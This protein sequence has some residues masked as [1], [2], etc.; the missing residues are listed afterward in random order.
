MI[1]VHIFFPH[2]N[3]QL[4]D[5]FFQGLSID[6]KNGIQIERD[7]KNRFTGVAYVAFNDPEDL[8]IALKTDFTSVNQ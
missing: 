4:I 8:K 2:N 3:N 7:D 6:R 1:S 5:L